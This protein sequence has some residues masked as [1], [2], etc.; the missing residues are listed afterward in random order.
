MVRPSLQ[1]RTVASISM[2]AGRARVAR[3]HRRWAA[4]TAASISR[5]MKGDLGQPVRVKINWGPSVCAGC[6]ANLPRLRLP[7]EATEEHVRFRLSIF[8]LV[9]FASTPSSWALDPNKA[10]VDAYPLAQ[11][12]LRDSRVSS[13]KIMDAL[14]PMLGFPRETKLSELVGLLKAFGPDEVVGNLAEDWAKHHGQ[15][16]IKYRE[17]QVQKSKDLHLSE[18]L[19][20]LP[21]LYDHMFVFR[22]DE[23]ATAY[24]PGLDRATCQVHYYM[25]FDFTIKW[26]TQHNGL[27]EDQRAPLE[28]INKTE[29]VM[30][31]TGQWPTV[32]YTVQPDGRGSTLIVML[33]NPGYTPIN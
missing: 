7:K 12:K 1:T 24:D 18:F 6:R 8:V 17:D 27:T 5:A 10:C 21:D 4:A 29:K 33:P 32:G 22:D 11:T 20:N 14:A 28:A 15:D 31:T 23:I 13:T 16:P 25:D 30:M 19:Q 2:P 9:A 3:R 26:Y